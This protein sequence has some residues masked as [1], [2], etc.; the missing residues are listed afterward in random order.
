MHQRYDAINTTDPRLIKLARALASC[1]VRVSGTWVTKT[2]YDFEGTG[3]TP[4]GYQN[5]LTKEQWIN[6]LNIVRAADG[7]LMISVANC[8]GLHTADEPWPPS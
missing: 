7:K 3:V 1:L 5:R 2:Y 4:E 6:L 8:N